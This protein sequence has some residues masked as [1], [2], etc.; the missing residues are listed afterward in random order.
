MDFDDIQSEISDMLFADDYLTNSS[1]YIFHIDMKIRR[2][3]L[4]LAEP[5]DLVEEIYRKRDMLPDNQVTKKLLIQDDEDSDDPEVQA[6]REILRQAMQKNFNIANKIFDQVILILILISSAMLPLD[7]P[8]NDPN[9]NETKLI[10]YINIVFTLCFISEASIKIIAKGLIS[11][12]LGE[13]KPY[14]D[15]GWN[16]VD[17]FVVSISALDLILMMAGRGS[18]FAALKALRALRALRPLRVIKRFENLKLIVNALFA[19]FG[20]MQNVLMVG[21]LLLLIFSIMG[22]SFFKGRFFKCR[23][24][25]EGVDEDDIITKDDCI[26]LGGKWRN[27]NMNF[28]NSVAAMNSLFLMMQGEGWTESMYRAMDST[29]IDMQPKYNTNTYFLGFF[30][31]YMIVGSLFISNLFVGVVIDNF[32][33]IKEKNELG[34]AFVTDNQRQWIL[35]Q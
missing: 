24:I 11:N 4:F 13:I 28:D 20:A 22:V 21:T 26:R 7:N 30:V 32:N 31:A 34:S 33:K 10:M 23:H 6:K 5:R 9:S 29:D 15:S 3:C 17:A 8:L 14:L 19:T 35:M 25:P 18:Q 27:S 2:F 16:R 1:L 12:N